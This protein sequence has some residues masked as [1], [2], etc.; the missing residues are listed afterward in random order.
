[1]ITPPK[2]CTKNLGVYACFEGVTKGGGGELQGVVVLLL[3]KRIIK[4]K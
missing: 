4:S 1:M 2:C 3:K